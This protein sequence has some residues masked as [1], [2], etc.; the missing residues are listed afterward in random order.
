MAEN[1]LSL[2]NTVDDLSDVDAGKMFERFWRADHSRSDSQHC[3]LGLPLV[4]ACAQQMGYHA[5][6]RVQE[7]GGERQLVIF[8]R[9]GN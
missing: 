8:L 5:E 4:Q 7:S 1:V 3:G 9:R 6:A 2:A